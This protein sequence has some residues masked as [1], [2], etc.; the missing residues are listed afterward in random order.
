M[1]HKL[2]TERATNYHKLLKIGQDFVYNREEN[3]RTTL[4]Y[5]LPELWRARLTQIEYEPAVDQYAWYYDEPGYIPY[6]DLSASER[7]EGEAQLIGYKAAIEQILDRLPHDMKLA[8]LKIGEKLERRNILYKDGKAIFFAWGM[9]VDDNRYDPSGVIT[10]LTDVSFSVSFELGQGAVVESVAST[11]AS[12]KRRRG[13]T[14]QRKDIPTLKLQ[15]HYRFVAWHPEPQGHIVE[16]DITFTAH[17]DYEPPAEASEPQPE[18][19]Q[20]SEMCQVLFATEGGLS[21]QHYGPVSVAH[22]ARL[23]P[24]DLPEVEV[25]HEGYE[26]EGWCDAAYEPIYSDCTLIAY[27][28]SKMIPY[29]F[30]AG[31]F[32][33]LAGVGRG[34]LPYGTT[35]TEEH[36]PSVNPQKG[37]QFLGWD[38]DPLGARLTQAQHFTARYEQERL[39][40]YK[41]FWH[42]LVGLFSGGCLRWL[43]WALLMLFLLFLLGWLLQ[44]CTGSDADFGLRGCQRSTFVDTPGGS[45]ISDDTI[46]TIETP[47]GD[48]ID[49]NSNIHR[50]DAFRNGEAP[51]IIGDDGKLPTEG[52]TAPVVGND[53]SRAPIGEGAEGEQVI[54]NRLNVFFEEEE[55]DLNRFA[56]DFKEA[57]PGEEYSIVGVDHNVP[58]VQIQM[59]ESKRAE[60]RE[61]LPKRLTAQPIFVI[62]EA[63]M[64]GSSLRPKSSISESQYG[65]HLSSVQAREAWRITKGSPKVKIAVLDDGVE[66]KHPMFA[67]K[68]VQGYNVFRQDNI[69]SVGIGHGTHIAG[70]A[71]GNHSMLA[72][73]AAGIAPDCSLM[74]VQVA[75]NNIITV[76]SII[77]GLMYALNHEA[78]VINVSIGMNCSF[79][80][81]L[82]DE[83][84]RDIIQTKFKQEEKVWR[85]VLAICQ[86]RQAILVFAAGNESVISAIDPMHRTDLSITVAAH[87]PDERL[88]DFTNMLDGTHIAAPGLGIYSAVPGGKYAAWDGTSMSA[89]I[90]AGAI[91]LIKSVRPE[92]TVQELFRLLR[93]TSYD[94]R[95]DNP[96]GT[97]GQT[98]NLRI[99][100]AL[101]MLKQT[102]TSQADK[103]KTPQ[104]AKS[105]RANSSSSR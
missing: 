105:G 58:M 95:W 34:V 35:F 42:W 52:V 57:Y 88:T 76:S 79:A 24:E 41:R 4:D 97:Y 74:V 38:N 43:L 25:T 56:K 14:L 101:K 87:G 93:E 49:D 16:K 78:D 10:G 96:D 84:Q 19:P 92:I 3:V 51:N 27:S 60:L 45:T 36:V 20:A 102:E 32:G 63:V 23:A 68:T 5:Y 44:T 72:K 103:S 89:P 2:R 50:D 26:F 47:G 85:K 67:G 31:D 62:D 6:D 59:P 80:K 73:G 30:D 69:L 64:A 37:Y 39:P 13:Y 46:D 54:G 70:I 99:A 90:V 77:A 1:K 8:C 29:T 86:K 71:A 21:L 81:A 55:V 15:P 94:L 40:W 18:S 75:D 9:E 61:A 22:G 91:A 82:P 28:R 66:A 12:Y 48:T 98:Y 100:D 104:S 11:P 7:A 83:Q 17:Y 65:W 53:G 33:L